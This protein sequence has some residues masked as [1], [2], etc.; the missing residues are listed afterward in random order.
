L[1]DFEIEFSLQLTILH[2]DALTEEEPFQIIG[3]VDQPTTKTTSN[4]A[5]TDNNN[6]KDDDVVVVVN[7]RDK[8]RKVRSFN[9][10]KI[11]KKKPNKDIPVIDV[12]NIKKK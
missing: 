11:D 5:Q 7:K 4:T 3:K 2:S 9:E 6:N 8:K 12:E 10:D 1:D